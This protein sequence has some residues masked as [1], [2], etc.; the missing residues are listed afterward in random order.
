M[1]RDYGTNTSQFKKT[2]N[3]IGKRKIKDIPLR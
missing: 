2:K 3:V 1:S